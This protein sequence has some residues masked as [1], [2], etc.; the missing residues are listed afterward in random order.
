MVSTMT[1]PP[2][3]ILFLHFGPGGNCLVEK[4][5]FGSELAIEWWDQPSFAIDDKEA[6][7]K[8]RQAAVDKIR[9]MHGSAHKKITV[10]ANSYGA[11]LA[12]AAIQ[13]VQDLIEH[14][15]ILGSQPKISSSYENLAQFL[16]IQNPKNLE[17][18]EASLAFEKSKTWESFQTLLGAISSVEGFM[19]NYW[20][21]KDSK[22]FKLWLEIASQD[23]LMNFDSFLAIIQGHFA[24]GTFDQLA[25]AE[26]I[27]IPASYI[28]GAFDPLACEEEDVPQW[29]HIFPQL[30][31]RQLDCGHFVHLEV[32][33]SDWLSPT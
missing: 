16:L 2:P 23:K 31:V 21:K 33:T 6:L 24:E 32:A 3:T 18:K 9:T 7:S 15:V 17:L 28:Y 12:V 29:K 20:H 14:V 11:H 27:P 22:A 25:S 13:E 30:Q 10:F 8:L 4:S 5:I 19:L 1:L 26:A